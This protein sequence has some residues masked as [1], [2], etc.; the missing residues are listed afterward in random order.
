MPL[1]YEINLAWSPRFCI[2]D[3]HKWIRTQQRRCSSRPTNQQKSSKTK[4]R[5]DPLRF[6]R[7]RSRMCRN[8]MIRIRQTS[9]KHA[10]SH[11]LGRASVCIILSIKTE[12]FDEPAARRPT[13]V[14]LFI[15]WQS[16][17]IYRRSGLHSA[18]CS[19]ADKKT[20]VEPSIII[21]DNIWS[22]QDQDVSW[23]IRHAHFD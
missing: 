19:P 14:I 20:T 22:C 12:S 23:S 15:R 3:G 5:W 8:E 13:E 1:P 7:P 10:Y 18:C 6:G 2:S 17:I 11:K 16:A 9:R 21:V 4:H